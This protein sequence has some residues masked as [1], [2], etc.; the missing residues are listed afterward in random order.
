MV[1]VVD[2]MHA[3]AQHFAIIDFLRPVSLT[4]ILIPPCSSLASL[5]V[6]SWQDDQTEKEARHIVTSSDVN[7]KALILTD[8]IPSIKCRY[9]KVIFTVI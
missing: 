3:A 2:R 6:Y 4:D 1:L 8:V 9:L 5:S 7:L